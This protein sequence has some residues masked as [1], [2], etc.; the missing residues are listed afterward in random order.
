MPSPPGEFKNLASEFCTVERTRPPVN[1]DQAEMAKSL[2]NDKF[3]K[4]KLDELTKK[5]SRPENCE[6][7]ASS[8]KANKAVSKKTPKRQIVAEMQMCQ[9]MFM[10]SGL[11]SSIWC[12]ER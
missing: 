7:L 8:V 1:G 11:Y 6:I 2:L 5:C 4:A 12:G 10:S 9:T 3:P